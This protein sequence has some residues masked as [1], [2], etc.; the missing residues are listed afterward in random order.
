IIEE[1]SD[2]PLLSSRVWA[3]LKPAH[4]GNNT[5]ADSHKLQRCLSC[6]DEV[7]IA[8]GVNV[9]TGVTTLRSLANA[10][11]ASTGLYRAPRLRSG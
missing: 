2:W 3:G 9:A 8:T 10:T 1:N 4:T 5:V 6:G 7:N 11:H